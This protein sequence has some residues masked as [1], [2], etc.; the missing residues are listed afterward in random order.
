MKIMFEHKVINRF[1]QLSS[2]TI[3]SLLPTQLRMKTAEIRGK[4]DSLTSVCLLSK[5]HIY[6]STSYMFSSSSG[7]PLNKR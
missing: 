6:Y 4:V 3:E 5:A 7:L 2:S 1:P